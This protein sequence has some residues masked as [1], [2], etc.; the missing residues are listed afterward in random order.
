[1]HR[2]LEFVLIFII[3]FLS[4]NIST[5]QSS[6][7]CPEYEVALDGTVTFTFPVDPGYDIDIVGSG[8]VPP[9]MIH[10]GLGYFTSPNLYVLETPSPAIS[11]NFTGMLFF[12]L[13][14]SGFIP[15]NYI[16]GALSGL[17][18]NVPIELTA[19]SGYTTTYN[20]NIVEW[21]TATES[22]TRWI[23]LERSVD[24]V[25][26]E[27][28]ERLSAQGWSSDITTYK[29]EDMNPY[30]KTYYRLRMIDLDNT[31]YYS[32]IIFIERK[33]LDGLTIT[34]VPAKDEVFVQFDGDDGEITITVVDVQ[35][36]KLQEKIITTTIGINTVKI[37]ISTYMPGLYFIIMNNG[38]DSTTRRIIKQ[39]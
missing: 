34:P 7:L 28:V 37:N 10:E 13:I 29:A 18:G 39:E 6:P 27:T 8:G 15:C 20:T 9:T 38:I 19:F 36:R 5:A 35:G 16:Q 23:I 25:N 31:E 4:A 26:W 3:S 24:G 21:M 12:D 14:N 2:I 30:I 17:S 1:M 33:N 22:N 32:D 11:P